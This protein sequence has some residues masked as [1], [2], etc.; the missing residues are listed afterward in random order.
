[1]IIIIVILS[2]L[3]K[4]LNQYGIYWRVRGETCSYTPPLSTR[5][6]EYGLAQ[7]LS[8]SESP[9]VSVH[10]PEIHW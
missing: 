9:E 7:M 6:Q 4:P 3:H 1:M 2:V 10:W 5:S 8:E